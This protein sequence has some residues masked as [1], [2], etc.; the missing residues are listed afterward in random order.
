MAALTG[1]RLVLGRLIFGRYSAP[2]PFTTV[3]LPRA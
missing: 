2:T 1:R 3:R